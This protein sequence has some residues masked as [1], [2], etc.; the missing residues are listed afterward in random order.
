MRPEIFYLAA[1]HVN[2]CSIDFD[3]WLKAGSLTSKSELARAN[4]TG[5]FGMNLQAFL[6]HTKIIILMILEI[7]L[8]RPIIIV[9]A[10]APIVLYW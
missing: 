1:H 5:C 9:R 4:I 10:Q 2:S 7:L 3:W 8:C 6:I